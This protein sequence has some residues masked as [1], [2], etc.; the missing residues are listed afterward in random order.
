[1][2]LV[3]YVGRGV[4]ECRGG[5]PES[6]PVLRTSTSCHVDDKVDLTQFS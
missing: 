6:L 2:V 5:G 3:V 4:V 1:V